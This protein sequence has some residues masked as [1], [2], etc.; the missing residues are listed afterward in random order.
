MPARIVVASNRGPVSFRIG[1]DETLRA[2]RG[3]GGLVTALRTV[4]ASG[5]ATW[6]C[7]AIT[8]NDRAAAGAAPGGR[9]DLAGHDTGG[10]PV[11][12]LA[13][14]PLVY[15]RAYNGIAIGTLW[16][17]AHQMYD[18]ATKPTFDRAWRREW[19][20]YVT[21]NAAF[22]AALAEETAPGGSVVIQDYHL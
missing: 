3:A 20:A 7:A 2:H 14:D 13:L 9:L 19:A 15:H 8:D 6:V 16:F 12:M 22:A 10:A 5:E 17:V 4:M 18:A 11:R 1:D 21:V